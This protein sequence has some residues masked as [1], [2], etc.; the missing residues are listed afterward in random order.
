MAGMSRTQ[1]DFEGDVQRVFDRL[2]P[3][4]GD[5]RFTRTR[6]TDR[7][8]EWLGRL[9]PPNWKGEVMEA[10]RQ[11][12]PLEQSLTMS[13]RDEYRDI[14]QLMWDCEEYA[15][16]TGD[17]QVSNLA[18]KLNGILEQIVRENT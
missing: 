16:N 9:D 18:T 14:R 8:R 6:W 1:A 17:Q 13:A 15:E 4:P 7:Q 5:P 10:Q 2:I 11:L 3:S 12:P